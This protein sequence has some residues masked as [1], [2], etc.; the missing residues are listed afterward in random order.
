MPRVRIAVSAMMEIRTKYAVGGL[1]TV[2]ASIAVV[3]A[4]ALTTSWFLAD[5]RGIS[6]GNE[7]VV[8]EASAQSLDDPAP[9]PV[10][11]RTV[12]TDTEPTETETAPTDAAIPAPPATPDSNGQASSSA[13]RDDQ[14]DDTRS[15]RAQ[16][17]PQKV[18]APEPAVISRDG[19]DA[20]SD[21]D[22]DEVFGKGSWTR[23]GTGDTKFEVREKPAVN[24]GVAAPNKAD[25][26]KD[27]GV[28]N[29][30]TVSPH[31]RSARAD[32][33]EERKSKTTA[34]DARKARSDDSPDRRDW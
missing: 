10:P 22:A 27:S 17:A 13:D 16:R 15:E 33:R 18:A 20:D 32:D 9:D 6:T 14:A 4:V 19:A 23:R 21:A 24:N 26:A 31:K 1:G 8:V 30:D 29:S 11:K 34:F 5:A 7:T 28:E 25:K 3:C 12:P 2:A